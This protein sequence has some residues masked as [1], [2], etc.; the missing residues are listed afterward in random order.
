LNFFDLKDISERYMELLNPTSPEKILKAGSILGLAPGHKVIDFGCGFGEVLRLWAEQFGISGLGIDIRPYACERARQKMAS[1]GFSHRIEIACGNAGEHPFEA[2]SYDVAICIGATFIW[3]G[4][5]PSLRAMKA[6]I[7]PHG[8][9]AVG[10]AFWLT[11]AIPPVF[12]RAE[13]LDTELELLNTARREGFELEAILRASQDDWDTYESSNW[14]GLLRWIETN[15]DHP[16]LGQVVDHLHQSQ[17][18]Y[19]GYA[20]KYFG[21]AIYLLSP[22]LR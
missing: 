9:L 15:P 22:A 6:A 21:W 5:G 10:E 20:R 13:R 18:E 12:A 7:Q 4:F 3:D 11:D 14:N 1:N 19:L 17:E 2:H 16:E 8:K